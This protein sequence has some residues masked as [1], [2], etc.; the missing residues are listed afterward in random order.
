MNDDEN[1]CFKPRFKK[2]NVRPRVIDSDI[3]ID[4]GCGRDI[5]NI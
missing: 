1:F 4:D 3:T 2:R 5:E